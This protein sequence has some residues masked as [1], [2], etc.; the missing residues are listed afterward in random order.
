MFRRKAWKEATFGSLGARQ[1]NILI[2][3]PSVV[4]MGVALGSPFLPLIGGGTLE[5]VGQCRQ[6]QYLSIL[7]TLHGF[8]HLILDLQ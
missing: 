2:I 5:A 7:G 8:C 3:C 6:S 1:P 4:G